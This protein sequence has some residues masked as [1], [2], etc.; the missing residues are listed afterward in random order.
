M[1]LCNIAVLGRLFIKSLYNL[2]AWFL[3]HF[4]I[5]Q[6]ALLRFTFVSFIVSSTT[7]LCE[8]EDEVVS[9]TTCLLGRKQLYL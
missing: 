2:R 7:C 8:M 1:I 6:F 9:S 4:G 3:L 5:K